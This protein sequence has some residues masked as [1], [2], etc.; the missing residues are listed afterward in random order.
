[1]TQALEALRT[2]RSS[3]EEGDGEGM[4]PARGKGLRSAAAPASSPATLHAPTVC[5]TPGPPPEMDAPFFSA[6]RARV[7]LAGCCAGCGAAL[8]ADS[9]FCER[10]GARVAA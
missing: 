10:C 8:S 5:P 6:C 2:E 1:T 3:L 4:M 7:P 9:R